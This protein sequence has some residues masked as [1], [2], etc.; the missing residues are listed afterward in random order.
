MSVLQRKDRQQEKSLELTPGAYS[1]FAA[2]LKDSSG[3]SLGDSKQYLVKNRLSTVLRDSEYNALTDLVDAL[4]RGTAPASVQAA[5]LDVMTT[6]ETFW[7]RDKSHFEILK[8][9]VFGKLGS[10]IKIWSAACSSGQEPYSISLYFEEYLREQMAR[11]H[12]NVQILATDISEKIVTDARAAI[13]G[14][15]S[16][17]RGMPEDLKERYFKQYRDDWKLDSSLTS[18]VR[19]QQFNLLKSFDSL[20]RFDI[21]FIRN[22]LIYFPDEIKRTVLE[23]MVRVLNPGGYLFLSST[24]S[25]PPGFD[26][27]EPVRDVSG[28]FY[29]LKAR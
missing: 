7:F 4:G 3:I 8:S 9:R 20:G 14:N 22:V 24:E 2:Y 16:L 28:R 11:S 23:R 27:L 13:Y 29:Q 18:R 1:A 19:F 17:S 10:S 5:I 25:L 26:L 6:N 15:M 12:Q 21:I